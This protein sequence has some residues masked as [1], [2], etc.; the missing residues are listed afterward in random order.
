MQFFIFK[1]FAIAAILAVLCLPFFPGKFRFSLASAGYSGKERWKNICFVLE[2]LLVGSVILCFAPYIKGGL[3][4]LFD[5]KLMRWIN[6]FIPDRFEYIVSVTVI[7]A[8]NILVCLAFVYLKKIVRALL[9]TWVF[10][11]SSEDKKDKKKKDKKKGKNKVTD[12]K[13]GNDK[14]EKRL[15]QLRRDSI[16]VF[17]KKNKNKAEKGVIASDYRVQK[18]K[19]TEESKPLPKIER[20]ESLSFVEM[21]KLAWRRFLGL[22]YSEKDGFEYVNTG[23]YRWA[24]ELK[25]FLTLVCG[26]Y[27]LVCLLILVPIFFNLN[28]ANWFYQAAMWLVTNTYMYPILSIILLFELLWFINGEHKEVEEAEAP[29]TS[30]VD[31][32]KETKKA[33]LEASRTALLEK[34]GDSY[35]I[36]NFDAAALGG[37]STYNLLEKKQFVQNM[38]KAIRANRGFIN[39]DY[40]Q[41]IEYMFDGKHVLF[42]SSLYSALGEYIVHYLFVA[43]SF[44]K[45]ALFV[46]KDKKEIENVAAYLE[47]GFRQITKTP[48]ILWRISTFERMHEGE[49]PDVLL[50]TPEQFLERSLFTDGKDFFDELVDVFVLDADKIIT[51]N[52]YYCL[53]MAKKLEKATTD[54]DAWNVA[55]ADRSVAVGKRIRYSFFSNGHVQALGN[56]IRQ[57]FN[58]EDAPLESFHSFGLASK[59]EVFVWHTGMS[60]TL[61]VDNGANQVALEVQIAKD[62]GNFGIP[63]IN[64][65]SETA[66]YSSQLTEIQGLTLNS[67]DLSDHPVGYVI[68]AD[69]HFNLP[70]AIYNF[71]RFSG[72][73]ATVL[74]VVSKPYLLRDYFT[75]R[76]EDYVAHFEL[77]GN[78]MSEH[79]ESKRANIIIL[80]CDAVNGIE[81]DEFTRRARELLGG[82]CEGDKE[83]DFKECI[84]LCYETALGKDDFDKPRYVLTR[85]QDSELRYKT[86]VYIKES[87]ELFTRLLECTK[88]VKLEY[89]NS[90]SEEFLPVFKDEI[91]QHFITGQVI[92]RNNRGYT[93]KDIDV[94]EGK[95]LLDD[96]GP[97]VNVPMDYIQTR[98][99]TV[100]G[101]EKIDSFGNDYRAKNSTVSHIGFEVYNANITA[102]TVGYYSIE[103]AIQNVNLVKPNF[104]K[105]INL[106]D[107]EA[108]LNKIKREID[109]R[110]L[111]VEL[112]TVDEV[113]PRVTYTLSVILHEF[114]KTVFPHQYRCVSVCP[115]FESDIEEEFF[116]EE[117]AIRDLYPRIKGVF[118]V[119]NEETPKTR[120]RF[121]IIEDINGGNG[122][123]ET[124]VDGG[125]IM[126]ANLLHV[127]ADFL[128]WLGTTAAQDYSYLNFG[129]EEIPAIFDVAKTEEVIRQFRHD[130]ERSEL[131]RLYGTNNCHFCHKPLEDGQGMELEDGRVICTSCVET[132][133]DTF[134]LLQGC[135]DSVIEVIKKSTSVPDSFPKDVTVDFVSTAELRER[136]G[137]NAEKLPL[138]YCN[139]VENRIYIEYG[140][141]KIAVCA[142]IARMLT[143]LWQDLN[144]VSDG[145]KLYLAHP[146]YVEIQTLA[147][148][149][150]ASESEILSKLQ[151][152]NEGLTELNQAL[153]D[154]GTQ[155][156]FAYFLGESGNDGDGGDG[157]DG[158]DGDGGKKDDDDSDLSF[159]AERD[160]NSLPRFYYNKLSD[161]EKAVYDQIYEGISNCVESVG[162]LV[163]EITSDKCL[164]ILGYV[165][166]DNADIFW[167]AN[168]PGSVSRGS[169]G[170]AKSVN[171]KYC[172]TA[173]EVKRRKK[174]IEKSIKSFLKGIK[175]SMSDYEVAVRTHENIVELIDYDSIGLEEQERDPHS[176]SKPDNLRSIYGVFVE[177]KAVCAGY[178]RAYQYLLNRFGI[179][180]A[181]VIGPCH[182]GE[183]HAWNLIKLEGEYYYVDCTW[184]DHTNTDLRKSGSAEIS[185]DYFCITTQELLKSR[186]IDKASIY[187]ECTSKKCNYFV[188]SKL[189]FKDYDAKRISSVITSAVKAGKKEIAFKTESPAVLALLKKRLVNEQGIFD[190]LRSM[191]GNKKSLSYAHY[192]NDDLNILHIIIE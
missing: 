40:M 102:E 170:I 21:V 155:D 175:P 143:E 115:L 7:L 38:A 50:L 165:I 83:A 162:P 179:E 150:Y 153:R 24:K 110:M 87:R 163:R 191:D 57:F 111:V 48:Q 135:L 169:D 84:R 29:F 181:Y 76:A 188:R 55:D 79:A 151:S 3:Q 116:K 133:V 59:T 71:S 96:T 85:E 46:C 122:I 36:K 123:V 142:A 158:D 171:F 6:D 185:H 94:N 145:S 43:L 60:S 183:W 105:Y 78:T 107:N 139:H 168:P 18:K 173:S 131:V 58:L 1:V 172:M 73:K 12:E 17:G 19:E 62:V 149:R 14:S 124:L 67:C 127:A 5:T 141:P 52:N 177:E 189:F 152:G 174:Q 113:D 37:K 161:D 157:G 69:D 140:L 186:N 89:A 104:A 182:G 9:D 41:S 99:Y 10:K 108:L 97:S 28:A 54:K 147:L 112:D 56:S 35:R 64:L 66:V 82:S 119:N 75:S 176:Y 63:N 154:K 121:A 190:I 80:L 156:S 134:E 68:V 2:T 15:K 192:T 146:D 101:A 167:L 4:W 180:C 164:E 160:P 61:Y 45:R 8:V 27:L 25:T 30:F 44:G 126:V 114:M 138:A 31:S 93:I 166:D 49:K 95:L 130:V 132:S 106:Y 88:T 39:G 187:P 120:I 22:F 148:L 16:L 98:V 178:A 72:R 53:I 118:G 159:I 47:S 103:K 81:R 74:H 51:A 128:S 20:D 23:T 100:N 34:Y 90:Q 33:E 92:S 136:Y 32:I 42:D 125:G 129:Y 26:L 77:I 11:Q 91:V 65:I 86:F 13:D 70:N 109:T 137:E 184:D 117:T 144:I